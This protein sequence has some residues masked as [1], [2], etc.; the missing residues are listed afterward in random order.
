MNIKD[1]RLEVSDGTYVRVEIREPAVRKK[2][3][4]VFS[5]GFSVAAVE[6]HR[7]FLDIS[8]RLNAL[9]YVA[10]MFDYRGW[11]SSDLSSEE[12]TIDTEIQD[13]DRVIEYVY[14]NVNGKEKII[15]WGQSLGSGVASLVASEKEKE[16][17]AI[18]L[19]CLS[20]ELFERYSVTLGPEIYTKGYVFTEKGDKIG[21]AFL[22]SLKDK[23]VYGAIR[24][25]S[26]PL[27]FVHG[28]ED[29]K[30]SVELT[31]RAFRYAKCPKEKFIVEGGNHGFKRQPELFEMA[32]GKTFEWI[33]TFCM[34][35]IR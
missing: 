8:N 23:D 27:L 35:G 6:S 7:M 25:I 3:C 31:E 32:V 17:G 33:E 1:I 9:G 11:G 22:D 15:L 20:A 2:G 24:K 34:G 18:V 28:T 19:W 26:V 29:K 21:R 5:H 30:A 16:I 13:L 12:V 14:N 4:V 10:V